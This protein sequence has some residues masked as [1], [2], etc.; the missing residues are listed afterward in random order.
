[1]HCSHSHTALNVVVVRIARI[2]YSVCGPHR[3]RIIL[4]NCTVTDHVEVVQKTDSE[5]S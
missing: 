5:T 1:V 4:A 3:W 2:T